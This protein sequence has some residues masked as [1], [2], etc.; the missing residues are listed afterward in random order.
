M[1]QTDPFSLHAWKE[2]VKSEHGDAVMFFY[3]EKGHHVGLY[4]T[5]TVG[6]FAPG[7]V[8]TVHSSNDEGRLEFPAMDYMIIQVPFQQL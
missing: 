5:D 2:A 6:F 8:C 4:G 3:N 7:G 1:S